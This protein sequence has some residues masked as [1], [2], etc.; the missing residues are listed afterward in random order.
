MP[1]TSQNRPYFSSCCKRLRHRLSS[2][3]YQTPDDLGRELHS[4]LLATYEQKI[5]VST[6]SKSDKNVFLLQKRQTL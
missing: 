4:I 3:S 1:L 6:A 5:D 2:D